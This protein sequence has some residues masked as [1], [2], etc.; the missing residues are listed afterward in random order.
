MQISSLSEMP[1]RYVDTKDEGWEF[2]TAFLKSSNSAIVITTT[3]ADDYAIVFA[4]H[5]FEELTGYE[6]HEILGSNCRFLQN[7]DRR[8]PQRTLIRSMLRD[9]K[10]FE[11]VIRNYTKKG[12]PFWNR[13]YIFPLEVDGKVSNFVSIQH[14]ASSEKLLLS[15]AKD[16]SRDR[17]RLI[18]ELY[19]KRLKMERL[20]VELINAQEAERQAVARELHDEL[21]QRLSSVMMLLHRARPY[22]V[23]VAEPTLLRQAETDVGEL[24]R[25]VRNMSASLRPPVL[26]LFGLEESIRDLLK[27]QLHNISAWS[28]DFS[29]SGQRLLPA[30]EISI[31]RIIQESLTNIV[32][33]AR[34]SHVLVKVS[35][36]RK[37]K[38]IKLLVF[39]NGLGFDSSSWYENNS[40]ASKFGLVGISERV[41]LLGGAYNILSE[42]NRGTRIE[43]TLPIHSQGA[44]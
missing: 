44:L 21:G 6:E 17:N 4:N 9:G 42:I 34:A 13:M 37:G 40:K 5:A 10:S 23:S 39:D 33:H 18:K 19:A 26:D 15:A 29:Y 7:N 14:D 28:F 41:Q 20:S 27:R 25:L 12:I 11:C 16:N 22:F 32:R 3:S 36:A 1:V 24:L 43:V 31:Y 2:L 38:E 8:Q 35:T 30:I